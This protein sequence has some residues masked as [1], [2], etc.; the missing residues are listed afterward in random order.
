MRKLLIAAAATLLSA[1]GLYA[2]LAAMKPAQRAPSDEKIDATPERLARGRYLAEAVLSCF[3]CHSVRRENIYGMPPIAETRGAGTPCSDRALGF[4]GRICPPNITPDPKTGIGAW[5]DGEL[6]RAIREG[7]NKNGGAIFPLMPYHYYRALS[8]EDARALVAYLRS[9]P[10]VAIERERTELDFPIDITVKFEPQPLEGPVAPPR[11]GD[12]VAQGKYLAEIGGC[13]G[14][15]TPVD[16]KRHM[17]PGRDFAGGQEFPLDVG[18]SVRSTNLTRDVKTG[19]GAMTK[20]QFVARFKAFE[21]PAAAREVPI[22]RN[23][24]MPWL[25]YAR[26]TEE[27]LSA[28]YEY[29]QTLPPI[30]NPIRRRK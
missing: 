21:D 29:L 5:S 4:P 26:M 16:E 12:A 9:I 10:A 28:I 19:M 22:D 6:M 18:V 14:C 23:T 8:D 7:V 30:V 24:V 17:I 20:E 25:S 13:R 3:D 11:S 1:A 2:Y 15:H 27:D